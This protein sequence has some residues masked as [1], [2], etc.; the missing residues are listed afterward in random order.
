MATRYFDIN[1]FDFTSLKIL[2]LR[3]P[4]I[5][6]LVILISYIIDIL[7]LE[8][9]I[10]W[11]PDNGIEDLCFILSN[12]KGNQTYSRKSQVYVNGQ[13]FMKGSKTLL[14]SDRRQNLKGDLRNFVAI[15]CVVN[16]LTRQNMSS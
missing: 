10:L 12:T 4:D 1:S 9:L 3:L 14:G 8:I 11:L 16:R 15:D 5:L 2:I 7:T 6:I 13:S